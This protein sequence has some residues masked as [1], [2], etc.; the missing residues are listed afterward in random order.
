MPAGARYYHRFAEAPFSAPGAG[1]AG[2]SRASH[3]VRRRGNGDM[4]K[5]LSRPRSDSRA[6]RLI[7]IRG[8]RQHNLKDIDVD[9][10]RD[11]L[12]VVTGV[13]GSGKSTLAFDTIYAEG[14]RRY[15]ESLS[16]Y[17][18]QFLEQMQKPDVERIEGLTPT[19]AI[20]QRAGVANPRSTVATTTEVYDYLRLL[21]ARV[22]EPHCPRCGRPI[23]SQSAEQIVDSIM[24]LP[25]GARI[26][27]LSVLVRG[28]KGEHRD[29][30]AAAKREGFVRMRIDGEVVDARKVSG[31][32][33]KRKH[34]IEAVVD[35]LEI[36]PG[37]R[38]RLTDSVETA[39]RLGEGLMML[40]RRKDD[41]AWDD[42]LYSE[43]YACPV[44]DVS[45]E[46]LSP[47]MFSFNS[48]YGACR[49]CDGLGTRMEL[50]PDLIVPDK[51]RPLADGAIEAWRRFGRH[52]NI[53]YSRAIWRFCEAF[54]CSS[55]TPFER[56]PK[57]TRDILLYGTTEAQAKKYGHTFPGV[58]PEL[59]RRFHTSESDGVKQ[60][61]HDYMSAL[62]CPKCKGARLRPEALAVTVGKKNIRQL[63][64]L[65]IDDC[66]AT[67]E[68]LRLSAERERIAAAI[69]KEIGNRLRFL[70]DV[71]L[72]YLTLDRASGTLAGGEAERL[73]LASQVGS[74]LVGVTYVLDEPTIGLHARDNRKLLGTLKALRDLGNTVIVVEHDEEMIRSADHVIDLGP[75]AGEHGGRLVAEGEPGRIARSKESVTGAYL[76]GKLS[77]PVPGRR[78]P[79]RPDTAVTVKGAREN[80]LKKIDVAFPLGVFTCV[81]GVSGSGKS[82]LVMDILYRGLAR[83]LHRS[84]L[85]PGKHARILGAGQ[86]DKAIQI[87][88][89]PIGRTPRSNP[90][91][92]T[93]VFDEIRALFAKLPEAKIR[94]YALGRF[95]F[96]VK[97]GRC[98]ACEGQ[99]TKLIEMHFL[100]DV[101]VRCEACKGRRYNRETIEIKYRGK[102]IADV[103]EM[104][105]NEALR[106]FWNIPKIRTGLQTLS[107][108]GL[109]YVRLGQSATTLSGGEA[110]R[111]KLARELSRRDT[112]TTLYVLDEPTTGLHFADISKLLGVLSRLV[113]KGNTV[114]V[115]EHNLDVVKT[116]DWII[117]LGPEGGEGGGR[118][119]AEG[120]P[121]EVARTKGSYTGE[122]L[123][124]MLRVAQNSGRRRRSS[125]A[126]RR[127]GA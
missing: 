5:S 96:N 111:V 123:A 62:P 83:V 2:M 91:T 88:Q 57:G 127:A 49:A 95:S 47:R 110:Q 116:A 63:T 38:S 37:I 40:A 93:G 94:G 24:S 14:Q 85:K 17:A 103:L 27:V 32:D 8:A 52:L 46:E 39:L 115:I 26:M 28:R 108:V 92:Y 125:R 42:T 41:G 104:S 122:F 113:E 126:R 45:F 84:R 33:K 44:C 9:I 81:T 75:G 101:Y 74:R 121:E 12:V 114:V 102:S 13:S 29:V 79:V 78:R 68:Q 10:P 82:T 50:D 59:E 107:D 70:S 72:G 48:P 73:R 3:A 51:T 64:R 89:S 119:V 86:L 21:F 54:G 106:F 15:V 6:E 18:R 124:K 109:G 105:V 35:R 58:I 1:G 65:T 71:G 43:L 61:I 69:L 30:I 120:P 16:A 67:F 98:E 20:E 80:N 25:E 100:P 66:V 31:L 56:L 19:I 77:I 23:S 34:E 36:R 90:V 60:K 7:K 99:G 76:S 112:G 97:G 55:S 87:T 117:D 118:V 11:R 22:G 4:K 53:F